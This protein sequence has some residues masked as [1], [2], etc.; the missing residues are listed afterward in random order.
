M[1]YKIRISVVILVTFISCSPDQEVLQNDQF[2]KEKEVPYEILDINDF[3]SEDR[4]TI[5]KLENYRFSKERLK[6]GKLKDSTFRIYGAVYD[7]EST[8]VM[9]GANVV[10]W[11]NSQPSHGVVSDFMDSREREDN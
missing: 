10:A 3:N 8:I 7:K 9:G 1:C 6:N 4:E 11:K 2:S 5:E